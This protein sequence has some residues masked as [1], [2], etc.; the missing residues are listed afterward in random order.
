LVITLILTLGVFTFVLLLGRLLRQLSEMLVNQQLRPEAALYFL[1][2]SL[3]SV[4]TYSLPM[5]MLA[6][7]L[8]VMGRLGADNEIT[9]MRASGISLSEIIAPVIVLAAVVA[10][11]CMYLNLTLT[12]R[13]Q[14][15]FRTLFVR[16]ATNDPMAFLP[17][18]TY[19][20]EFPGCVIYI[21]RKYVNRDQQNVLEEVT[22]YSLDRAGNVISSLRAQRGYVS[23][24]PVNRKLRLDLRAVRGDLRD[25]QDPANVHK[26]RA[27]TTAERYPVELDLGQM[28]R[29]SISAKKVS[30]LEWTELQALIQSLRA[31]GIYPAAAIMTAHFRVAQAVACLAF[32]LIGIPLGFR[33][34]RRETSIGIALS[35]GLALVWYAMVTMGSALANKPFL[36]P[37]ALL[38]LPNFVFQ[39]LGLWLLWRLSRV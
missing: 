33:T 30:D 36:Y 32:A 4:L 34:S 12:P 9:A 28:L 26:I 20:K 31:Q 39:V 23:S 29:R 8:L 37:E 6:T 11:G 35:L 16:L 10:A 24:D 14:F 3:P 22:L 18:R 27:G 15:A 2:L 38:W 17:E 13:C 25:A 1:V 7:A 19:I 21:G 5:A